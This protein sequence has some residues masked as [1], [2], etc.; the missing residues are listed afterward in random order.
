[1]NSRSSLQATFRA[2]PLAFLL[3]FFDGAA[4]PARWLPGGPSE[5]LGQAPEAAGQ[6]DPTDQD[7][8]DDGLYLPTDRQ[9]QRQLDRAMRLLAD[10]RWSDAATLL[11]EILAADNDSF[12]RRPDTKPT[13]K[14]DA[15][16]RRGTAERTSWRSIK[17]S[18]ADL[19]ASLDDDGR[20]AYELQFRARADRALEEA[21]RS[22]RTSGVVAVARRWFHTPAGGRAALLLAEEALETNQPLAAG[23]WL[24]R[25]LASRH[26]PE[27]EPTLSVMR[28]IAWHRCGETDR[29]VAM[30]ERAR[31]GRRVNLRIGGR[32]V[33]VSYPTGTGGEW[34]A[35]LAGS[36]MSDGSPPAADWLVQGGH[37]SR[38]GIREGFRPL[39]SP[40][41]RVNL[42]RHP[43]EAR[44][45]ERHRRS[46]NEQDIPLFPAG[47]PLAVGG[48]LLAHSSLGLLA[49]DFESGKRVWLQPGP[50]G[51]ADEPATAE[52]GVQAAGDR[53]QSFETV[54]DDATAGTLSSDGRLV[55]AV[56]SPKQTA[57]GGEL[58]PGF[59]N[60]NSPLAS[61]NTLSAYDIH[62]GGRLVWRLPSAGPRA[63]SAP[64]AD[65]EDGGPEPEGSSAGAA[66]FAGAPL[67]VGEQLYTIVEEKGSVRLEVLDA[68]TGRP[69]WSQPLAELDDTRAIDKPGGRLR[70][71]AGLSPSLAEGVLVCPTGAG[72]VVGVDLAAR[73][74]IWAYC[75]QPS[76]DGEDAVNGGKIIANGGMIIRRGVNG[77]VMIQGGGSPLP[78]KRRWLD[79]LPIIADGK[80]LLTPRDSDELYCLDLQTG[81]QLWT[82]KRGDRISIAGVVDGAAIVVGRHSVESLSLSRGGQPVW[83]EP[84]S[85]G[86]ST[87]SGRGCVAKGRLFL[88]LDTPEVVE[89]DL[90]RGA[91]VGRS[92]ARGGAGAI[93]HGGP[94]AA[95]NPAGPA[96]AAAGTMPGNLVFYRGEVVSQGI[97]SIDVFHQQESL[98]KAVE[99]VLSTKPADAW[100][101][102]WRGQLLLDRGRIADGVA[103]VQASHAAD[104]RRIPASMV[105]EAMHFAMDRDFTRAS[106]L[107]RQA[108]SLAEATSTEAAI[109]RTAVDGFLREGD[110]AQAWEAFS[111]LAVVR[112]LN[113]AG[114]LVNDPSDPSLT[115]EESRW[116]RGRLQDIVRD[117]SPGARSEAA[118]TIA[119][120]FD[121]AAEAEDPVEEVSQFLDRFDLASN[122]SGND[123]FAT[124]SARARTFLVER[125][126]GGGSRNG[127]RPTQTRRDLLLLSMARSE[128]DT[129]RQLATT[130]FDAAR[131]PFP[132]ARASDSTATAWPLGR[133][134]HHRGGRRDDSGAQADAA[135][136]AIQHHRQTRIM[137]IPCERGDGPA[138]EGLEIPG[139][140]IEFD[141]QVG[142]AIV[143]TDALGRRLGDPLSFEE[144]QARFGLVGIGHAAMFEASCVGRIVVARCG[145][146]VAAFE[147]GADGSAK[148]RRLWTVTGP[149]GVVVHNVPG[150]GGQVQRAGLGPGIRRNAEVTLGMRILEPVGDSPSLFT[151]EVGRATTAG[152]PIVTNQSLEV[153]DLVSGA[154]LWVRHRIPAGADLVGDDRFLTVLPRDG[155][156]A[157]VLSMIDGRVVRR[158]DLPPREMR[159][160]A[161]GRRLVAIES[162]DSTSGGVRLT[163]VDPATG[164]RA[165]LGDFPSDARAV[166]VD[167]DRH[168]GDTV[169]VVDPRGTLTV[170]DLASATPIFSRVL[171]EMP[172]M[173]EQLHVLPWQDRLL[174]LVGRQET[175]A[176][177]KEIERIGV[178]SNLA[179]PWQSNEYDA[180]L[181]GAIWAV[182]RA[183]G[184]SLW[185]LPATVLRQGIRLSQ[186]SDLPVLLFAR[187]VHTKS[188][189]P[190]PRVGLLC[191]DKRTGC[192]VFLDER[193]RAAQDQTPFTNCEIS[194][195]PSE[196]R[197]VIDVGSERVSLKFDGGPIAPRPPFQAASH[198]PR[199]ADF[200]ESLEHLMNKAIESF[201]F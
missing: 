64:D 175:P 177:I 9:K 49:I 103:A 102:Y 97:G 29:A 92:L 121:Q 81:N 28:A 91:I 99:T 131:P 48:R 107:W 132:A 148:N 70:R 39:L 80:V 7:Q 85:L 95:P 16:S 20:D 176:E 68:S 19:I 27:F 183:S 13:A 93:D 133:V 106:G 86:E 186:P 138:I 168:Q 25:L 113:E 174:V 35:K 187:H 167:G 24:D 11:D 51:G 8:G 46:L 158:C 197:V 72:A 153:R 161:S 30:I 144:G 1:M 101:L 90:A 94:A 159:L 58:A 104:P 170:V 171:D 184:E 185:P 130:L 118:A 195:D 33:T 147:L 136:N 143:A 12:H 83:G 63:R 145:G 116:I 146:T 69:L 36:P 74:L 125:L 21:I 66:W 60:P 98:E 87:P 52:A 14:N 115:C 4:G 26:A 59:R 166:R 73:A 45:L 142:N 15:G 23:A 165:K 193:D 194:G 123:A 40:R 151:I 44:Q 117:L 182:D 134:E 179:Q 124:T 41:Y 160:C 198:P 189:A 77:M 96:V 112:P 17:S 65:A 190:R 100:A 164:N 79:G 55:F 150:G 76:A 88:P 18:A 152:V 191:L 188:R 47:Q 200:W 119:R 78:P 178:V 54:F 67:P 128:D 57:M 42:A 109:L 31:T 155:R 37:P 71:L 163:I 173:M 180:V 61:N 53:Q 75:Y 2:L 108:A 110:A 135:G 199:G 10:R 32:D 50:Y 172:A 84:L 122:S 89:I 111:R 34:L 154:V 139:L 5:S 137:P 201:P 120:W 22:G 196:H 129:M 62:D 114:A 82:A 43:E 162:D 141:A 6:D 105:A 169:A 181:T 126:S 56:E 38:N 127:L 3:V 156:N 157:T 192:D 149:H 140:R